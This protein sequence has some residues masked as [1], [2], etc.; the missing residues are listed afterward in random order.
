MEPAMNEKK[1]EFNEFA[2][3]KF[4][5]AADKAQ[6]VVDKAVRQIKEIKPEEVRKTA[7]EFGNRVR[8][9]SGQ[10]YDGSVGLVRRNPA[11]SAAGILAFGF[12]TG[13]IVGL[14][15]KSA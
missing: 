14:W 5:K 4:G 13:L 1:K 6:S 7:V 10:L 3:E 2:D 12:V 15:R 9:A 11:A 8:D